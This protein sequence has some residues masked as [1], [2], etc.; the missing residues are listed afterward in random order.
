MGRPTKKAAAAKAF[1]KG[2]KRAP[3]GARRGRRAA[4]Q[5]ESIVA[6]E[7]TITSSAD[8]T[9]SQEC[10][11]MKIDHMFHAIAFGRMAGL[12]M[13]EWTP[14]VLKTFGG[15]SDADIKRYCPWAKGETITQTAPAASGSPSTSTPSNETVT[16]APVAVCPSSSTHAVA[17]S[18]VPAP[19]LVPAGAGIG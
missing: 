10:G 7:G 19:A 12:D 16:P 9:T 5:T 6:G 14:H 11:V 15:Y 1:E 13:N 2:R 18:N 17:P 3:R 8:A 4:A